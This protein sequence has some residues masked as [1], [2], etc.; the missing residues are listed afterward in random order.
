MIAASGRA[1]A[2]SVVA[3][4]SVPPQGAYS[5][6]IVGQ[7][8]DT[9]TLS[10]SDGIRP[11]ADINFTFE[12]SGI[13]T[14]RAVA[15]NR[16]TF[17]TFVVVTDR[18]GSW[19]SSIDVRAPLCTTAN[20]PSCLGFLRRDFGVLAGDI[21]FLLGLLVVVLNVPNI[22][23]ALAR[24]RRESQ[25]RGGATLKELAKSPFDGL[26]TLLAPARQIAATL[27]T[28]NIAIE[29]KRREA[30]VELAVLAKHARS[31]SHER[32]MALVLGTRKVV[33]LYNLQRGVL[34][35]PNKE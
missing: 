22:A 4:E 34:K 3:P 8:G 28:E 31:F 5:I 15:P 30:L 24:Y 2:L 18:S 6:T 35:R 13:W 11:I 23:L 26:W 25:L 9:G 27:P 7:A 17:L 33:D 32:H 12:S 16:E 29:L 19:S 1:T 14:F 20:A 21:A 10:L